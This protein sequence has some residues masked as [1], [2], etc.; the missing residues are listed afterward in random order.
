MAETK[1]FTVQIPAKTEAYDYLFNNRNLSKKAK[2]KL[3][4]ETVK[5][6]P[7]TKVERAEKLYST[8]AE[9]MDI[10]YPDS[11]YSL[12][13]IWRLISKRI[14]K[15]RDEDNKEVYLSEEFFKELKNL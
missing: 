8:F 2:W 11:K 7:K 6:M 9:E 12:G 13:L 1:R 4:E 15:I 5:L 14:M 10:L 3:I